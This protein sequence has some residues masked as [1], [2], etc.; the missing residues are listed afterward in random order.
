MIIYITNKTKLGYKLVDKTVNA[1]VFTDITD[2]I[3]MKH[4]KNKI[5]FMDN[6][7]IHHSLIFKEK[8][9]TTTISPIYNIPYT[10]QLNPSEG[11]FNQITLSTNEVVYEI[12]FEKS[13]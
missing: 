4:K 12:L 1:Q 11:C 2:D 8:I 10:P 13:F 3:V 5:L 6:A 9:K 7:R